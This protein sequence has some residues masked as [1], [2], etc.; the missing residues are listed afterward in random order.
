MI[1]WNAPNRYL[2][3]HKLQ[4]RLTYKI[5]KVCRCLDMPD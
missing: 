1:D 5:V 4:I 2:A 3:I